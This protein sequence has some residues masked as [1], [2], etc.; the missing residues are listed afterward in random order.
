[1]RIQVELK[2]FTPLLDTLVQK[3]GVGI[4]SVYGIIWRYSQMDDKV[5]RASMQKM[6]DRLNVS[7]KTIERHAKTLC[8]D[9]YLEDLT[10]GVKNKPHIYITTN[11]AEIAGVVTGGEKDNTKN[12]TQTKSRTRSD[13]LSH[14]AQ[15][16]CLMKKD[17]KKDSKETGASPTPTTNTK[18]DNPSPTQ[19]TQP[20]HTDDTIDSEAAWLLSTRNGADQQTINSITDIETYWRKRISQDTKQALALFH[21]AMQS[22]GV[23]IDIP[24]DSA[25][26][27]KWGA[28][29]KDH[30]ANYSLD[31]LKT[32][33]PLA[34][35][36]AKERE[37]D[38]Y[39]PKSLTTALAKVKAQKPK[40]ASYDYTQDPQYI[41]PGELFNNG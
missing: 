15:T 9:G 4:A 16:N 22:S 28:G 8:Q 19:D 20:D 6:A 24:R 34:I 40:Q 3:Y 5:C 36:H 26:Q 18:T 35:K 14:H 17:S 25:T 1:M 33:Y 11:K 13:N 31:D 2:G 21:T 23:D 38:I 29:A 7:A 41:A 27:G 39:S 10:P 12:V 30:L 37:W 32:Y